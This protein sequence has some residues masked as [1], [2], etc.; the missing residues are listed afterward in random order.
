MSV[1]PGPDVD[2]NMT[3]GPICVSCTGTGAGVSRPAFDNYGGLL[4]I[5]GFPPICCDPP[6]GG[7][8]VCGSNDPCPQPPD[9]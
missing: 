3:V 6:G 1:G 9:D 7:P 5:V 8:I 2:G 4:R